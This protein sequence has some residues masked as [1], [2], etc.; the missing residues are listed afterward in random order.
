M[1]DNYAH[2]GLEIWT[3]YARDFSVPML[4]RMDRETALGRDW[5]T[6]YADVAVAAIAA[7]TTSTEGR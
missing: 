7:A 5:L 4:E 2:M 1:A 3:T 6:K